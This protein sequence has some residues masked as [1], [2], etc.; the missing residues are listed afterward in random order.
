MEL[1]FPHWNDL[2][3]AN[4]ANLV[5]YMV[6]KLKRKRKEHVGIT[7]TNIYPPPSHHHT[8]DGRLGNPRY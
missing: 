5:V 1:F 6:M 4:I 2:S 7:N 3:S 8:R